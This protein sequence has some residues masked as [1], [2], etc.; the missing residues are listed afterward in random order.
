MNGNS[1]S[2]EVLKID[3]NLLGSVYCLQGTNLSLKETGD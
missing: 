2:L 3:G 1:C